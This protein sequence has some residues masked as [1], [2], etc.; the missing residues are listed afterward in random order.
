LASLN[1]SFLDTN[2][3]IYQMD[4]REV[5][6]QKKCRELVRALVLR[7]E[8]VI[9]TQILQEFYVACTAKLKVKPILVKG[10]IHGFQNMEVVTVGADLINEAIDTSI[11]YQI[12]FWDSLVVV[13]A[14]SAKCQCLITEDLNEGQIIRNVK[15]QNP[16]KSN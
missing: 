16:M 11:Q 15:I 1:K 8:A 2:I 5:A 13:S 3:L 7:H 4:N 9:S 14:E 12:S 10:M 6:K